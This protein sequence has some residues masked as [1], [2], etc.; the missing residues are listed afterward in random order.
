MAAR[1]T[2][3]DL[4]DLVRS[5]TGYFAG[6]AEERRIRYTVD[7]PESLRAELDPAQI[8]RVLLNVLSN[9]FKYTPEAGAITCRLVADGGDAAVTVD[10]SGPGIPAEARPQIF[11]RYYQVESDATRR[12][13]GTGLGLA[14]A[15]DFVTLHGGT[16]AVDEAPGGGARFTIV[17]R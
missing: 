2:V 13:G 11:E 9:A 15:R 1:Y 10:D 14:I 4:A 12:A 7:A 16:I 6:L 8:G 5:T 3:A 17:C